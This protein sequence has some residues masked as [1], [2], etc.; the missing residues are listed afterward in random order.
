MIE[1]DFK[2]QIKHSKRRTE[3][4]S[5]N[6]N[7][8]AIKLDDNDG[9]AKF[10][11]FPSSMLSKVDYFVKKEHQ[12]Q[13]IELTDLEE[14]VKDCFNTL[15]NLLKIAEEKKGE[16][17]TTAE[18]RAIKKEVCMCEF[19]LKWYGSIAVVERLY[20]KNNITNI[21][22]QYQLLIVCKNQTDIRMLEVLKRRLVGMMGVVDICRTKD[23]ILITEPCDGIS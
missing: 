14:K 17:L 16:P 2:K 15:N 21:N 7:K 8:E 11:D 18:E 23:I 19:K 5:E 22:P 6:S 9:L 3:S 12:I 20:R 4:I 10:L 1:D 13:L